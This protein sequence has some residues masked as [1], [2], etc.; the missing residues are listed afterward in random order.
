MEV[1]PPTP[2][3]HVRKVYVDTIADTQMAHAA[4][5]LCCA[6]APVPKNARCEGAQTG[7]TVRVE[8]EIAAHSIITSLKWTAILVAH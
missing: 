4:Q 5:V 2:T 3:S 8:A 1:I 6:A 7:P